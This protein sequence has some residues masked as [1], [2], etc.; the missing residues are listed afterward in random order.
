MLLNMESIEGT[1]PLKIPSG[2]VGE[3]RTIVAPARAV[4]MAESNPA[5]SSFNPTASIK[6]GRSEVKVEVST[7]IPTSED[8][9]P[10]NSSIVI[11]PSEFGS[12]RVAVRPPPIAMLPFTISADRKPMLTAASRSRISADTSNSSWAVSMKKSGDPVSISRPNT[13]SKSKLVARVMSASIITPSA[14]ASD[15]RLRSKL[16]D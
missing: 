15:P 14:S 11:R 1:S 8:K 5:V 9:E 3:E 10:P 7:V 6:S 16:E 4:T 12:F 2:S 13:R